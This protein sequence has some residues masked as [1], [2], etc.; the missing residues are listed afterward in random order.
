MS[1]IWNGLQELLGS[2]VSFFYGL[3]PN[4]GVAIILLTIAVGVVLFP[5]TLK[6]TRSMKAMQ[7]LQPELKR[8]QKDLKH[9]K[10]ALQEQ[11]MALYKEHGVNPAAGCLPL[12]LQMPIW[13]ALFSVLRS[14]GAGSIEERTKW[15]LEGSRL[16]NDL[17]L[18][19]PRGTTFLW[20]KLEI[21]PSEAFQSSW[22]EAIPYLVLILV[23]MATAYYQQAQTMAKSKQNGQQQQVPGQAIM[24]IFPFF[25]G[26]ISFSMPTGLVVY[27]AAS[28]IFRIGQQSLILALDARAAARGKTE[29]RRESASPPSEEEKPKKPAPPPGGSGSPSGRQKGTGSPKSRPAPSPQ[30]SKKRRGKKRRR[31]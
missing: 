14:F 12:L 22:V 23:V 18:T 5:L 19:P 4:L 15:V 16:S 13:F 28:Q 25:F 21:T 9:D 8:L 3:I 11:T 29:K 1:S 27:F 10:Q 7:E 2:I 6:Q 26:F 31:N 24:K 30:A 20:M 17:S